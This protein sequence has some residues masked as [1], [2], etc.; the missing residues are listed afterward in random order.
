[1]GKKKCHENWLQIKGHRYQA[2]PR[3]CRRQLFSYANTKRNNNNVI[4]LILLSHW[5]LHL[6]TWGAFVISRNQMSRRD[7]VSIK[8]N[9]YADMHIAHAIERKSRR[10]FTPKINV[11]KILM[12]LLLARGFNQDQNTGRKKRIH[13]SRFV[14]DK[15]WPFSASNEWKKSFPKNIQDF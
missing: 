12:V 10:K 14:M 8:V 3:F 15:S 1:M 9:P 7:Y 5:I 11:C 13:L 4:C 6:N 2:F